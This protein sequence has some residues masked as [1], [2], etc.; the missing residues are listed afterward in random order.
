MTKSV[1]KEVD[2]FIGKGEK[3]QGFKQRGRMVKFA[4]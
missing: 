3:L 4:F 1:G 2:V